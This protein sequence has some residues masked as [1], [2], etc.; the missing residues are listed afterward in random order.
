MRPSSASIHQLELK[1]S[2]LLRKGV[3]TAGVCLFVS[4]IWMQVSHGDVLSTFKTYQA[5]SLME[6]LHWALVTQ[7]RG[8]LVGYAG[9]AL[10]V[11]LPILRVFM[12]AFLFV[13]QKEYLLALMAYGVFIFLI[14]SIFLGIEHT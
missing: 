6:T 11:A 1:I 14:A 7:D 3:L 10:L 12:T 4:W 13:K 8:L 5:Q 9:L 2:Q